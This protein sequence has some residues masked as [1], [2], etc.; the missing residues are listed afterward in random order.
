[1]EVLNGIVESIVFKSS[2]TGYTVIKF[3]EN[4]IIHTAVGVLPHVKEGQNLKITGSWVNHSQFG[5]QFK[6]EECEEILP[7]SKDGIEKYLSSGII[8]GIG[9]VTA[10]K[11]VNKFSAYFA[12]PEFSC[13]NAAGI[14]IYGYLKD[15]I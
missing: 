6:V 2:D 9:P 8:Q 14:A 10:K 13:D 5:K 15:I 7:T 3:R 4:N 1:M 12:K 11:I